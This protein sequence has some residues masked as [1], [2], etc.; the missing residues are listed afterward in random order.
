M[1]TTIIHTSFGLWNILEYE[2]DIVQKEL[3]KGKQVIFLFCKGN[4]I[5]CQANNLKLGSKLKKRRCIECQSRVQ[6]GLKWLS[7]GS[8]KL[9]SLEYQKINFKQKN[10]I[11]KIID[12]M[13]SVYKNTSIIN[14]YININGIDIYQSALSTLMTDVRESKP[15]IKI[16][17]ERLKEHIEIGLIS[18]YSALNHFNE[19][20][21]NK[22]YLY[23]GRIS[24]YRPVLRLAN[25]NNMICEVYENPLYGFMNYVITHNTYIHNMSSLSKEL[26]INFDNSI[27]EYDKKIEIGSEW[28]KKRINRVSQGLEGLYTLRQKKNELPYNLNK[29]KFNIVIYISSEDEF[30][31]IDE[32]E[33]KRPY[34]QVEAIRQ[35]ASC[36]LDINIWVRIHPNLIGVDFAFQNDLLE[37][38][39]IP[40]I[41]VIKAESSVDSYYLMKVADLVITSGSATGIEAAYMRK[42]SITVGSSYYES[43]HATAIANTHEELIRL[44]N[45]AK[46]NDLSGYPDERRRFQGACEYAFAWQNMG[47]QP[48]Y[49]IKNSKFGGYMIRNDEKK[50]I[51][52]NLLITNY[53]KLLDFLILFTDIKKIKNKIN[54]LI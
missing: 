49:L 7:I 50:Y 18:Y 14:E 34:G 38:E 46:R 5:V 45:T 48:K 20:N 31:G 1:E 54:K 2:L 15:D 10:E 3:D 19:W 41:S 24:H 44:I 33:K 43:F 4:Q 6:S 37:L 13:D 23:N 25:Q 8:G 12:D 36:V 27:V 22:V 11:N 16:Y 35:I 17:Y 52:S 30:A 26:K 29:E 28:Y 53:N 51:R 42:P 40:C 47:I 21:P 39:K 32:I 9:K